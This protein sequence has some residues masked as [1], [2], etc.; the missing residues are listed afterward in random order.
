M[1]IRDVLAC[2]DTCIMSRASL[3]FAASSVRLSERVLRLPASFVG[4]V[5]HGTPATSTSWHSE[6]KEGC[7]LILPF[8]PRM[9]PVAAPRGMY[10]TYPLK[11]HL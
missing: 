10:P 5:G 4:E 11:Q 9:R 6:A 3:A 7:L 2:G 1:P 8:P